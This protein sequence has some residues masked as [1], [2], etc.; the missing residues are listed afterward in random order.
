M[1]DRS[2]LAIFQ[3]VRKC[4]ADVEGVSIEAW[5]AAMG[6]ASR[7]AAMMLS[8]REAAGHDRRRSPI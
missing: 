7:I 4:G 1:A 3:R 5:S 6:E 2:E 8:R